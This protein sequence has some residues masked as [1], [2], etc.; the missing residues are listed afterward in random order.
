MEFGVCLT[1]PGHAFVALAAQSHGPVHRSALADLALPFVADLGEVIGPDVRRP[2]AIG[3]VD[4]H[5]VIRRQIHALIRA[6]DRRVIP[7]RDFSEE[8]ARQRL[9]REIQC[10]R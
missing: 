1:S 9:G 2:A 4:D 8:N 6:R 7:L 10:R 5:D 3:A